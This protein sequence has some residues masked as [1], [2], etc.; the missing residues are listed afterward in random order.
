MH[1][2][3]NGLPFPIPG[4]LLH[5][6]I[7]PASL[8]SPALAGGIF[9]TSATWEVCVYIYI[10]TWDVYIYTWE[11]CIYIYIYVYMHACVHGFSRVWLFATLWTVACQAPLSM[12]FSRQEYWSGLP[13]NLPS[14]V[15]EPA[16]LMSPVLVGGFFTTSATWEAIYTHI[17]CSSLCYTV[18]TCCFIHS[19]LCTD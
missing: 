5:P 2:H 11:V 12:G 10:Y 16:S 19:N 17:E 6:G 18:G 14:T 13:C 8:V 15:I 3:W 4:D 7:K 9:T 1:E